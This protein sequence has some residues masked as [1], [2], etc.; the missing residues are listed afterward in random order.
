MRIENEHMGL[1]HRA[2]GMGSCSGR[3]RAWHGRS[4]THMGSSPSAQTQQQ[5]YHPKP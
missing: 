1:S 4:Q 3:S 5:T 2:R